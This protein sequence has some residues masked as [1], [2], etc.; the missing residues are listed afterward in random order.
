MSLAGQTFDSPISGGWSCHGGERVDGVDN[1][2]RSG[3]RRSKSPLRRP[4]PL[5]SEGRRSGGQGLRQVRSTGGGPR[6]HGLGSTETND[7]SLAPAVCCIAVSSHLGGPVLGPTRGCPR[8]PATSRG[9]LSYPECR[10]PP[11]RDGGAAVPQRWRG[12][13]PVGQ[14]EAGVDDPPLVAGGVGGAVQR[15]GHVHSEVATIGAEDDTRQIEFAVDLGAGDVR[16]VE[17]ATTSRPPWA[18]STGVRQMPTV[19]PEQKMEWPPRSQSLCHGRQ[20][21]PST[22]S[23]RL[24]KASA[25]T[26]AKCSP[27]GSPGR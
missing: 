5:R 22:E 11:G 8:V 20:A 24:T 18:S 23:T 27:K 7:G 21:R 17:P 15:T 10:W 3:S 14:G 26:S 12:G 2:R 1:D 25:A 16:P 19:S 9:G 13:W 6:L 4:G